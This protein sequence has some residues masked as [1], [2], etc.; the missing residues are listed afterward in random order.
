MKIK[1]ITIAVIITILNSSCYVTRYTHSVTMSM[2]VLD[3]SRLEILN[4][5]GIPTEK[6]VKGSCEEWIYDRGQRTTNIGSS[7]TSNSLVKINLLY[8]YP[9][10]NRNIYGGSA[11]SSTF[12]N[13][14]KIIFQNGIATEYK[15]GINDPFR[16][17]DPV[18]ALILVYTFTLAICVGLALYL[19][20]RI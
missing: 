17:H 16:N 6:K 1:L 9:T 20:T 11:G 5:F 18:L 3:K 2:A 8:Y 15:T 4:N 19:G 10:N 14:F 7:S 13:H 12:N